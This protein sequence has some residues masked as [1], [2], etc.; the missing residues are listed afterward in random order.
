MEAQIQLPTPRSLKLWHVV[1]HLGGQ[2]LFLLIKDGQM[3]SEVSDGYQ[4]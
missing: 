4:S 2:P 3:H 1:S